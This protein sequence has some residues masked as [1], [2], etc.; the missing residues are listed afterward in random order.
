LLA[1]SMPGK[2]NWPVLHC[3][4]KAPDWSKLIDSQVQVMLEG[5]QRGKTDFPALH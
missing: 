1:P 3:N 4:A 2:L 5:G